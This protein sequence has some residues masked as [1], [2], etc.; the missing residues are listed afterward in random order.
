VATNFPRIG[1]A[2]EPFFR[3]AYFATPRA[4]QAI[5]NH[6]SPR[7]AVIQREIAMPARRPRMDLVCFSLYLAAVVVG[8]SM[9]AVAQIFTR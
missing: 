2:H 1:Q 4:R 6:K 5:V 8:T 3:G 7:W 9:E